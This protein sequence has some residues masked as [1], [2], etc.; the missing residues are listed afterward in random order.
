[1]QAQQNGGLFDLV[2][3]PMNSDNYCYYIH[4]QGDMSQGFFIDVSQ[5]HKVTQFAKDFGLD[6]KG[7]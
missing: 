7:F 6:P 3:I 4:P 5:A 2:V 1:M